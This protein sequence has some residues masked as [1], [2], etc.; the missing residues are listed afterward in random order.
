MFL[1]IKIDSTLMGQNIEVNKFP[2]IVVTVCGTNKLESVE[3]LKNGKVVAIRVPTNDRVKF[4]FED[5]DLKKGDT[6]YFYARATQFDG[7]RGWTSPIWVT[8]K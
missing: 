6:T 1:K 4:A 8:Y 2:V 5:T 3:L 7:E